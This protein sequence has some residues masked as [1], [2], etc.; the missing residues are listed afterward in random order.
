MRTTT[1]RVD[2]ETHA[3]LLALSKLSGAS[4]VETVRAATKAL[5]RQQFAKTVTQQLDA[6]REDPDS[7]HDYISDA[8]PA[9]SD[10]IG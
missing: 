5:H 1:I 10:G 6:L 9:V 3:Q 2:T 4:L 7:W 8:E